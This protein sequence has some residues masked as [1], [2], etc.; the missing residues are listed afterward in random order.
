MTK[1]SETNSKLL[2]T[3]KEKL[4]YLLKATRPS[5]DGSLTLEK[6]IISGDLSNRLKQVS[7]YSN[8]PQLNDLPPLE[9]RMS[10]R[11]VAK[12]FGKSVQTIINWKRRK[13]I[14]YFLIGRS[15]I[16]SRT[17]LTQLASRNQHLLNDNSAI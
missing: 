6:R 3:K 13:I 14:P 5:L 2:K 11:E 9:D 7:N 4:N 12:L 15:P 10:Q 16:Y 1:F 17:Q 8:K